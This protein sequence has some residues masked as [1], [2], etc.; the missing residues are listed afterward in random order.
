M[1]KV[2]P[3]LSKES[4]ITILSLL[5]NFY[6]QEIF[7]VLIKEFYNSDLDVSLSAITASASLGNELAIP[8][9]YRI[10]EKGDQAQKI[11]AI[12]TL[13][14]IKAPSSV[15]M[16]VKYFNFFQEQSMRLEIVKALNKIAPQNNKVLHLNRQI[17]NNNGLAMEL[18]VLAAQG[19][20]E[21]QDIGFLKGV[22]TGTSGEIS[23]QIVKGII[24]LHNDTAASFVEYLIEKADTFSPH[25]LGPFLGAYLIHKKRPES[26]F[27]LER[28]KKGDKTV[29]NSLL[30]SILEYKAGIQYPLNVF[31]SLLILP[32]FDKELE[33]LTGDSLEQVIAE[34]KNEQ[35]YL[36][37]E[38][39]VITLAHLEAL[40]NNVRKN[41]IS[42]S[43]VTQKDM[44]LIVIFANLIERYGDEILLLDIKEYLRGSLRFSKLELIES[45]RI[46]LKNATDEEKNRFSA[47]IPLLN[48]Q[49][50]SIS[51][52]IINILNKIDFKR[53]FKLRRLNRFVR[54]AGDLNVKTTIK[55]LQNILD[56][57]RKEHIVFLEETSIVSL[58]QLYDKTTVDGALQ[59]F[60]GAG[61]N[62]PGLRGY[63]RG[64]RYLSPGL[65][66]RSLVDLLVK[67]N[68]PTTIKE[69]VIESLQAM[70]LCRVKGIYLFMLRLIIKGELPDELKEKLKNIIVQ[71][72]DASIFQP[73]LDLTL[74][75]DAFLKGLAINTLK[76]IALTDKTVPPELLINRFYLLLDD[77]DSDIKQQAL[78]A[79][80]SL[81]DDYAIEILSD[82]FKGSKF[83]EAPKLL[84]R[85][86]KPFSYEVISL[87]LKAIFI[88]DKELQIT[89]RDILNDVVNGSFAE[90]I[91]K[92]LLEI[93][94]QQQEKV[95]KTSERPVAK[96]DKVSTLIEQPKREFIFKRENT[97]IL[98]VFFIDI[99]SYTEKSSLV[100]SSTLIG[101][102]QSFEGIVIPILRNFKGTLLKKMG[103]GM[104]SVFKHPL[105][106]VLSALEIQTKIIE[107]NQYKVE[108]EKFQVRIGINTGVV[109]RKHDDI[110]GD[111]VNIA[112]RMETAANPGDVLIT[113]ST[114]NEIKN[115][116]QCTE[117]GKINIKGKQ[118]P[119]TAYL[120]EKLKG[121]YEYLLK[122]KG[123]EKQVA[124]EAGTQDVLVGLKQ[125]LF[126]PGFGIPEQLVFSRELLQNVSKR[127][128]DISIAVEE[129][130]WDYQEEYEFKKYLQSK[131]EEL[132]LVWQKH[133]TGTNRDMH[134]A[135]S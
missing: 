129:I 83:K 111:V 30:K 93:L 45:V 71:C 125:S 2:K 29:L 134:N 131:W 12:K 17:V 40:F 95:I 103:D 31:K 44:L 4:I 41:F 38:L 26:K 128:T 63:I 118:E 47:C 107:H 81:K 67:S 106:A 85:L 101:L 84:K 42:I 11:A 86:E 36:L 132:L 117:L 104:L 56:F 75:K 37:N 33:A 48:M 73:L 46:V 68:I 1:E 50:K 3:S 15:N 79:L 65:F 16:L 94:K 59:Y 126:S 109:I 35:P 89:L 74:Q 123:D 7:S 6:D 58:C 91:R 57:A 69:L 116:I 55:L 115:Y 100:D 19:L 64:V 24:H 78:V 114:Y 70:E 51:L 130:A 102:I 27:I 110:F 18:R 32:Y 21:A 135:V 53:P 133:Q 34:I 120:V 77:K 22:I 80:L 28:L 113:Y 112:S 72:S 92:I 54:L 97:Q 87:L 20:M 14:E 52:Q 60:S 96:T 119:I 76:N 9:L 49:K 88:N 122:T 39:S 61:K 25:M 90:Q 8:H 82:Y 5:K 108:Q 127:F 13:A 66:I 121:D 10:L 43:D 23:E 99:A 124:W 105:N 98:T 62:L